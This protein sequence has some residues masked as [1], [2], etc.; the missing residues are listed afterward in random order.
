MRLS[1]SL[2][3]VTKEA[4]SDASIVSHQLMLRAGMIRQSGAGIYSWLPLGFLVLKKIESRLMIEKST[5]EVCGLL[6]KCC[7]W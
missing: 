7:R 6:C 2:I 1:N 3:P 5:T 4:P